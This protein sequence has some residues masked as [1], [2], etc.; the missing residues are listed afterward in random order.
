MYQKTRHSARK[1]SKGVE[2][3]CGGYGKMT[4]ETER[5]RGK[6]KGS[7]TECMRARNLFYS[8]T[9]PRWLVCFGLLVA[10]KPHAILSK[11]SEIRELKWTKRT[12][13]PHTDTECTIWH[14]KNAFR[15]PKSTTIVNIVLKADPFSKE[16]NK[17]RS[18]RE[19]RTEKITKMKMK[20]WNVKCM[21]QK[22]TL[23]VYRN[24]N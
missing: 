3:N 5:E 16:T 19:C 24:G 4:R 6:W 18:N 2:K 12:T 17:S 23:P 14:E 15:S 22:I 21:V 10:A 1:T 7:D 13:I 8:Y 11:L 9:S 20:M